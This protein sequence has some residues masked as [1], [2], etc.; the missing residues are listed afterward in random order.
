[1]LTLRNRTVINKKGYVLTR[2][3]SLARKKNNKSHLE[4]Q[5]FK[6]KLKQLEHVSHWA[7][8]PRDPWIGDYFKSLPT[9]NTR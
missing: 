1:M 6:N 9:Y 4:H 2:G 3:R 8:F 5:E 7:G